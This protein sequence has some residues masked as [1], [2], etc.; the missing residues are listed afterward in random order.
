MFEYLRRYSFSYFW[1]LTPWLQQIQHSCG[2]WGISLP[3]TRC[4]RSKVS[5]HITRLKKLFNKLSWVPKGT[6]KIVTNVLQVCRI[7]PTQNLRLRAEDFILPL[8]VDLVPW[9]KL[10]TLDNPVS[11]THGLS[12]HQRQSSKEEQQRGRAWKKMPVS[13]RSRE[14]K[15]NWALAVCKFVAGGAWFLLSCEKLQQRAVSLGP[16]T[17]HPSPKCRAGLV[18]YKLW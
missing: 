16:L 7:L 2:I 9:T 13:L 6:H 11:E 1:P 15:E 12:Y 4:F 10:N 17:V 3:T 5:A 8:N 14:E 18:I